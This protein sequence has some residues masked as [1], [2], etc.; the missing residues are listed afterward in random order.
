MLRILT[1]L[2]PGLL[3]GGYEVASRYIPPIPA[4]TNSPRIIPGVPGHP[5]GGPFHHDPHAHHGTDLEMPPNRSCTACHP[6]SRPGPP[7]TPNERPR[8]AWGSISA[9]YGPAVHLCF[10]AAYE[11]SPAGKAHWGTAAAT[12][13]EAVCA[14][15]LGSMIQRAVQCVMKLPATNTSAGGQDLLQGATQDLARFCAGEGIETGW[16]PAQ[17]DVAATAYDPTPGGMRDMYRGARVPANRLQY[18]HG[19]QARPGPHQE[20]PVPPPKPMSND[21]GALDGTGMVRYVDPAKVWSRKRVRIGADLGKFP[22]PLFAIE[23][24]FV[25]SPCALVGPQEAARCLAHNENGV[26][27][28]A[29]RGLRMRLYLEDPGLPK[30][31][32]YDRLADGY[33]N[34]KWLIGAYDPAVAARKRGYGGLCMTQKQFIEAGLS[35]H[36]AYFYKRHPR[37]FRG[38]RWDS[39]GGD[40]AVH[41]SR[42]S[43]S[44]WEWQGQRGYAVTMWRNGTERSGHGVPSVPATLNIIGGEFGSNTGDR[45]WWPVFGHVAALT[46]GLGLSA[47]L[48]LGTAYDW[49]LDPRTPAMKESDVGLYISYLAEHPDLFT[50][51]LGKLPGHENLAIMSAWHGLQVAAGRESP[52][53][54]FEWPAS[55]I[56]AARWGRS[57]SLTVATSEWAVRRAQE[58]YASA[59]GHEIWALVSEIG[60]LLSLSY[61]DDQVIYRYF[62]AEHLVAEIGGSAD[63]ERYGKDH[64]DAMTHVVEELARQLG[65]TSLAPDIWDMV[66]EVFYKNYTRF[67]T[68]R[69]DY[70]NTDQVQA[71]IKKAISLYKDGKGGP[72]LSLGIGDPTIARGLDVLN[73]TTLTEPET[74]TNT[75]ISLTRTTD[76]ASL[77]SDALEWLPHR[78]QH[79][80]R[81]YEENEAL[82]SNSSL[83]S[84]PP[85]AATLF[86]NSTSNDNA[87]MW[88]PG[89][90]TDRPWPTGPGGPHPKGN[91]TGPCDHGY[92]TKSW[93]HPRG[94]HGRP[95]IVTVKETVTT[96]TTVTETVNGGGAGG[97][98]SSGQPV[99]TI[100]RA[101]ETIVVPLPLPEGD[102]AEPT[103][104]ET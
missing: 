53:D 91:Y 101:G 69:D 48:G 31:A 44:H 76:T 75:A 5:H 3:L 29:A 103:T 32:V 87:C 10:V 46:Q 81:G 60:P 14:F 7:V 43:R 37:L 79:A 23:E 102:E 72:M 94:P 85:S 73:A 54:S 59:L 35:R 21:W 98:G 26:L 77:P 55:D 63:P 22:H 24:A 83:T 93:D 13:E 92:T 82:R 99:I 1:I 66:D 78:T 15:N 33:R 88:P 19:P 36:D 89:N 45:R 68:D 58:W 4:L 49:D 67:Q 86:S 61:T 96:T 95:D 57:E 20:N 90:I 30:K 51:D 18:A 65:I 80:E 12:P 2:L 39:R 38:S 16:E 25:Q 50:K 34:V 9:H 70:W 62:L 71:K 11:V 41:Y 47:G 64:S 84:A 27:V 40:L 100:E 8:P 52:G 97:A 17:L 6:G 74:A 28:E 42:P 104:S 56:L